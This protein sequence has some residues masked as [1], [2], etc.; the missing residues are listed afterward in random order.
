MH[1]IPK[2]YYSSYAKS[3]IQKLYNAVSSE[4]LKEV[5]IYFNNTATS[6]A[7][8]NSRFLISLIMSNNVMAYDF[9]PGNMPEIKKIAKKPV[10]KVQAA[11]K[12]SAAKKKVSKKA[13]KTKY[14][15]VNDLG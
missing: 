6:A 2:L 8:E 3:T 7:V 5:Y 15:P 11:V 9:S 1:G 10:K 12:K 4:N 14:P 13:A